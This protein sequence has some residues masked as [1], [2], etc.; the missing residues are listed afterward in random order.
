V[1]V[2]KNIERMNLAQA[3]AAKILGI[4]PARVS[5]LIH[6]RLG[7]FSAGTLIELL[8]RLGCDVDVEISK[9]KADARGRTRIVSA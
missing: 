2:T 3:E 9:S 1:A 7:G 8:N 4:S 6:G 5:A